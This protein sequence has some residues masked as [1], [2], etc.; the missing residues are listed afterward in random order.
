MG[1][2][3]LDEVV[4]AEFRSDAV[5]GLFSAVIWQGDGLDQNN[6]KKVSFLQFLSSGEK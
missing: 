5:D 4:E 3:S 1:G 6:Q 2:R